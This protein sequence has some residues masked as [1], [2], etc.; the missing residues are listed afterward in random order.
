M[1]VAPGPSVQAVVVTGIE[2]LAP[3]AAGCRRREAAVGLLDADEP[4]VVGEVGA[5]QRVLAGGGGRDPRVRERPG[6]L[7]G[8]VEAGGGKRRGRVAVAEVM[9]LNRVADRDRREER[10]GGGR[11]NPVPRDRLGRLGR[12]ARAR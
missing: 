10:H 1:T 11:G 9:A 5:E 6:P 2:K 8:G 3:P 4:H 12:A 7:E